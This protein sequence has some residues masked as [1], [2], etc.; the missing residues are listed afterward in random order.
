MS[1]EE[2]KLLNSSLKLIF[3]NF[4]IIIGY[5]FSE[6]RIPFTYHHD[7]VRSKSN[8]DYSRSDIGARLS[9]A[10]DRHSSNYIHEA[11]A[12][13]IQYVIQANGNKESDIKLAEEIFTF[14][15][16]HKMPTILT[17]LIEWTPVSI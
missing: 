6:G 12:G 11:Y 17:T 10:F 1:K 2:S 16:H 14:Y 13:A 9:T 4:S 7:F 5:D 3:I 15:D 8:G